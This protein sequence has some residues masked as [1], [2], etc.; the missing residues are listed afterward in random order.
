VQSRSSLAVDTNGWVRRRAGTNALSSTSTL[1]GEDLEDSTMRTSTVATISVI[2]ASLVS[3]GLSGLLAGAD[4]APETRSPASGH[5]TTSSVATVNEA[6]LHGPHAGAS[7]ETFS[8]GSCSP[9]LG[10]GAFGWHF[11][12]T[13]NDSTFLTITATF[14]NAGTVTSFV[15]HPTGKHAYVVTPGFDVLLAASATVTGPPSTFVL[16]HVCVPQ[17]VVTTTTAPETTTTA[18][19]TTT[20]APETTTTAPETTT[21]A[22]ET[23]TTVPTDTITVPTSTSIVESPT[24]TEGPGDSGGTVTTTTVPS[25]GTVTT[26][27][28]GGTVTPP[29]DSTIAAGPGAGPGPSTPMSPTPGQGATLAET[30]SSN[31][32]LTWVAVLGVLAGSSL[33]LASRRRHTTT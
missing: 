22:P 18:P 7:N 14:Q 33:L 27:E 23:T 4:A 5:E 24:T 32:S 21:T 11:V 26:T 12:L 30:G 31:G 13:G 19:E 2:G 15:S 1:V 29:T 17:V 3:I 20:T 25:G 9:P 6:V 10:S 28:P 8:R 16:S